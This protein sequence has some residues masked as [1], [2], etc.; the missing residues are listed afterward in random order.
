[1]NATGLLS[2]RSNKDIAGCVDD[3]GESPLAVVQSPITTD[4]VLGLT[5]IL[6]AGFL[7]VVM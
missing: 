1:M 4:A 5:S 3:V 7:G 6:L 2:T